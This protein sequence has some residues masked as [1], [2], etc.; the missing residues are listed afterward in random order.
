MNSS[1]IRVA[2]L[3]VYGTLLAFDDDDYSC[4]PRNRLG[5]FFDDCEAREIKVV[6]SSDGMTGNVKN[7]LV[8]AFRIANDRKITID[9]PERLGIDRFDNFFQL[10]QGI[11]DFSV[12][13]G[14]YD[15]LPRELLVIGDNFNKDI[16]GALRLGAYAIH[17]PMYGVDQG[18]EWDF[19]KIDL[20]NIERMSQP[21]LQKP[22]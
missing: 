11:K 8:I 3:D 6:T 13:I 12:I 22:F 2:A 17:C 5:K 15:I 16:W 19:G 4:P 21:N 10:D 9:G 20:D 14:H 18:K 7:D 1:P